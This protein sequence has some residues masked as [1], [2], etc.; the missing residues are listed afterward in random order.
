[1]LNKIKSFIFAPEPDPN[2][3]HITYMSLKDLALIQRALAF[4]C[5][6]C[7]EGMKSLAGAAS[8]RRAHL[9]HD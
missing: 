9:K 5:E 8:H 1:M 4:Y 2:K 3:I 6:K 7:D